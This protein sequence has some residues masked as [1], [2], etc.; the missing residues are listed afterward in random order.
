MPIDYDIIE[1][2]KIVVAK[3]SGVVT[4]AEVI[5]HLDSLVADARYAAPMKKIIDY[6]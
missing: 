5:S 3:G 6:R 1:D 4:G 2:K